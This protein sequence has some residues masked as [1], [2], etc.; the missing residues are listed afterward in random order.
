MSLL[1]QR[2]RWHRGLVD[3]LW[4]NK[5]MFLNPKY[6]MVGLFGYPYFVFVE[7]LGP[8]VEFLGY[9]GFILFYLFGY[10][11]MDF[12]LLF[13]VVAI[14]WGMW[15]NLG[16]VLLDNLIYRRYKGLRDILK[17][18]LFGL[19]EFL[20]YRQLI[21]TERLF[22]TFQ[23]WKKGWGKPKRQEIKSE[24]YKKTV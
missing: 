16:S 5:Q 13:F 22:A 6:G 18:C 4:V 10:I 23:F 8:M 15:I 24:A 14:L 19:V 17:L 20:G 2:N 12:A 11:S 21:V 9:L 3:S 7:A 1:K